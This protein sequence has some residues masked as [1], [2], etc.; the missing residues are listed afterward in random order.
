MIRLSGANRRVAGA[1][2]PRGLET[3]NPASSRGAPQV[4]DG[5]S[6]QKQEQS[7]RQR[8]ALSAP[9]EQWQKSRFLTGLG[10]RFG[11]TKS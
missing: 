2:T 9:H 4:G 7:Q 3:W 6:I 5:P 10:A 1:E 11:M 8:T